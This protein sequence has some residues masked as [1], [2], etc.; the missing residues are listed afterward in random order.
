MG[1]VS[2]RR[3]VYATSKLAGEH[4]VLELNQRGV[5]PRMLDASVSTRRGIMCA[6]R[7]TV[8]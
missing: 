7:E 6:H 3:W 2:E 5:M 4:L 1:S 8:N